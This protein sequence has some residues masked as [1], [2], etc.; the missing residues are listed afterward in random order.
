MSLDSLRGVEGAAQAGYFRAYTSLF[1]EALGFHGRNRR[2]PRDAVNACLSLGYTL[3]HFE[4]VRAAH[5][6]GLDPHLGVF[7][8]LAFGRESLACDLIEPARPAV[9]AWVWELFRTR[10]LRVEHFTVDKGACLL[11]KTG[12]ARFYERFEPLL[13]GVGRG[14]RGSCRLLARALRSQTPHA[15]IAFDEEEL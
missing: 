6:A 10:A 8:E 4:A 13:I 11:E 1:P 14:L 3:V 9:D 12:R 15:P 5:S 7:H 2:P